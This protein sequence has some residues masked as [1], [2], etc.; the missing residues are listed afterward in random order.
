LATFLSSTPADYDPNY[1]AGIS[2]TPKVETEHRLLSEKR[3]LILREVIEIE[4]KLGV[5]RRWQLG[6]SEYLS[7]VNYVR[8]R[9]YHRAL[10]NLKKLVLQCL[11][12][13]EK[14]NL[15]WTS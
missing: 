9:Q 11:F 13:L 7:T 5:S 4:V 8:N 12:E 1:G 2:Q 3:D 6:D 14:L 15:A 10:G